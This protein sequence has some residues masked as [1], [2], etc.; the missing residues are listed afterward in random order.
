MSPIPTTALFSIARGPQYEFRNWCSPSRKRTQQKS[1]AGLSRPSQWIS[2]GEDYFLGAIASLAALAT[3]NFT[4]VLA[5]I[6][7]GSPVCGLR[8]TRAL[9]CAFTRRPKP[10]TTNTPFFLVSLMAV[11]ARC[12]RNAAACLLLS[13]FFS[14]RRRTSCV[15]VKPAAMYFLLVRIGLIPVGAILYPSPVEITLFYA[16]FCARMLARAH[17]YRVLRI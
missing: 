9:R 8:P 5:L 2:H 11:S 12:S 1:K 7:M 4:T 13:S 6:W 15:L 10:G 14:A 17:C 16:G 3:R